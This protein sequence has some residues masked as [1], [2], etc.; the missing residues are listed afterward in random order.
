MKTLFALCALLGF[1]I[2][3]FANEVVTHANDE[4]DPEK[5]PQAEVR[6]SRAGTL[7]NLFD[8]GLRPYRF[9]ALENTTLEVKHVNLT[10]VLD[11]GKRLPTMPLEWMHI[12]VFP[13]GEL[14]AIEAASPKLTLDQAR[15]QMIMWLPFG[16]NGRTLTDLNEFLAAVEADYLDFDD[17]YRGIPHGCGIGWNEPGFRTPGGGP[18]VG[19]GFRKTACPKQ[20]LRLYFGAS[21]GLNRPSKDRGLYS[22]QPI[23]PPPGYEDVDMSAPERFGPDS[24]VDVL[25]SKGVDKHDYVGRSSGDQGNIDIANSETINLKMNYVKFGVIITTALFLYVLWRSVSRKTPN[26]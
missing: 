12:K 25:R 19:I 1:F 23:K 21:W 16:E 5:W 2:A 10:I 4:Y 24:E 11:S 18:K 3:A 7:K 8:A 13:D 17:P 14:A 9:P 22:P 15:Q 20:P 6:L 26:Y